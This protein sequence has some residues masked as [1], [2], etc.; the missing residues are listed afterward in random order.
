MLTQGPK[1]EWHQER[2]NSGLRK[3]QSILNEAEK[4]V[5]GSRAGISRYQPDSPSQLWE[6]L[7]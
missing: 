5:Q 1:A 3:V 6:P 2:E 4:S 7:L